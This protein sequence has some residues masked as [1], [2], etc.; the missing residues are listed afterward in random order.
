MN[1]KD[2][3]G[4]FVRLRN[5]LKGYVGYEVPSSFSY[6]S[7]EKLLYPF[8]GIIFNRNGYLG[9]IDATWDEAGNYRVVGEDDYD[10]MGEWMS[11][12]E[13]MDR[14]FAENALVVHP[15]DGKFEILGE[16]LDEYL[17]RNSQT[18]KISRLSEIGYSDNWKIERNNDH[19]GPEPFKPEIGDTYYVITPIGIISEICEN[20]SI[21][22]YACFRTKEDALVWLKTIEGV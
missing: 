12:E 17:L 20:A 22:N 3:I 10:V 8:V 1:L 16:Y 14:A 2:Y 18:G 19:T 9:N 5:G 21:P 4:K 13:I 6:R 7:G 11:T 15:Y